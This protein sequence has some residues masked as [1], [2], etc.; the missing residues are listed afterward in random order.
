MSR[1]VAVR[2]LLRLAATAGFA[3]TVACFPASAQAVDKTWEGDNSNQWNDPLNWS[4]NTLPSLTGD[5]L[6]WGPTSAGNLTSINNISG[7]TTS[8]TFNTG[9]PGNVSLSGNA[10]TLSGNVSGAFTGTVTIGMDLAMVNTTRTF[11]LT[12]ANS[13]LDLN[14]VISGGTSAIFTLFSDLT[15][16]TYVTGAN[17]FGATARVT[18]GNVYIN[19]LG[20]TGVAQSLGTG[21]N[22]DFGFGSSATTGN[23]IY[24]GST[25]ASTNKGWNLGQSSSDVLRIHNGGFFN[26]GGGTVT[27]NGTQ[28]L[29]A[30][31]VTAR[32]FT[33]G[34]SNSGDN[35]W[36]TAIQNN[37]NSSG[38]TVSLTKTGLGKWIL[39]G[40]NTYTGATT[41]SVG[42]LLVNGSTAAGSAVSVAANAILGGTGTI[43]GAAVIDGIMAPGSGGIGT[44]AMSSSATWNAGNAWLF[45]LGTPALS[46]AA[47]TAG[48]NNDLLT[49]GGA[50]TQGT[51][52]S[53]A[54][55]FA[56]SGETGWYKLVDYASTTFV[57][58]TNTSFTATNLP[59]GKTASFVVDAS[60]TALYVQIV[61]EPATL[62]LAGLGMGIVGLVGWRRRR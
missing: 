2:S 16:S 28:T 18:R 31:T 24:T 11:G 17:T 37:N 53:F 41:V 61:P 10:I 58:G 42:T 59:S 4:G 23:V 62:A 3:I 45:E 27:W 36:A 21:N 29:Q 52:S 34:G 50:F 43:G 57:T 48:T 6:I 5:V 19:T 25:A 33:L 30:A 8:L 39:G 14:G 49:I 47:A 40:A 51:G 44:L 15:S 20:N 13:R 22:V 7:L 32:T 1:Q 12:G 26:D 46:L 9:I 56:N 54:F 55:N 38:G 35:T 60:S